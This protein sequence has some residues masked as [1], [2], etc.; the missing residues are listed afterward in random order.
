M[1]SSIAHDP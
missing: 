1:F